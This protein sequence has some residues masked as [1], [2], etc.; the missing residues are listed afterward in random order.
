[1]LLQLTYSEPKIIVFDD[2]ANLIFPPANAE[3]L[4][5]YAKR[6]IANDQP[7][8]IIAQPLFLQ[9]AHK[10]KEMKRFIDPPVRLFDQP[11]ISV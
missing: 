2:S 1:M 9:P 6:L 8:T 7:S 5:P 11:D 3:R 10:L 4:T